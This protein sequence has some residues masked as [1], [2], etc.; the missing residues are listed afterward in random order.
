M[1][2]VPDDGTV[3]LETFSI[4]G[5]QHYSLFNADREQVIPYVHDSDFFFAGTSDKLPSSLQDWGAVADASSFFGAQDVQH[6]ILQTSVFEVERGEYYSFNTAIAENGGPWQETDVVQFNVEF[7]ER[8]QV[9]S[10]LNVTVIKDRNTVPTSNA[11][12][13]VD[14]E[15]DEVEP[16][17]NKFVEVTE[18]VEALSAMMR[19]TIT[20]HLG[21]DVNLF[22]KELR[23]SV[24]QTEASEI[25]PTASNSPFPASAESSVPVTPQPPPSGQGGSAAI[26]I[27]AVTL[28][29]ALCIFIA[30][31]FIYRRRKQCCG[32]GGYGPLHNG[33]AQSG[34]QLMTLDDDEEEEDDSLFAL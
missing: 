31:F 8:E 17:T 34:I 25:I 5:P 23:L 9:V 30:A 10:E 28:S 20:F 11:V 7:L 12:W 15:S 6:T 4:T 16:V 27:V 1:L 19:I 13:F 22:V 21:A 3:F 32:Q 18:D 24:L 14:G 29:I 2:A 26:V 33:S